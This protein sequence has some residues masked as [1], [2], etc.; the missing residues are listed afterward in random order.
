M[1]KFIT[2]LM[3][4]LMISATLAACGGSTQVNKKQETAGS[5][6]KMEQQEEPQP[7][8]VTLDFPEGDYDEIGEGNVYI[9]NESGTSEDGNVPVIFEDPESAF[10][11]MGLEA[12]D[13]NGKNLT[14]IYVDGMEIATEQLADTQTS[15]ELNGPARNV[16][17]H[18]VEIVQY[19][20]D[21]PDG[22]IITYRKMEYEVKGK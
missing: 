14:Y 5:G 9:I 12:W 21:K 6:T 18:R 11:I 13:F 2:T 3:A 7:E 16:G 1:K 19:D 20:S 22:E 4:A 17:T 8:T 10:D 15:I